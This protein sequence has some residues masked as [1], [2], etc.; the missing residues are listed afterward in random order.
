MATLQARV[1]ELAHW[2]IHNPPQDG[3]LKSW[4]VSYDQVTR[5]WNIK[6]LEIEVQWTEIPRDSK[7][8]VWEWKFLTQEWQPW[9]NLSLK[10]Q[11]IVSLELGH[12]ERYVGI[13]E[14]AKEGWADFKKEPHAK[15]ITIQ[16]KKKQE[17]S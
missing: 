5:Q 10:A 6:V 15:N 12:A 13:T 11:G 16:C 14:S 2:I 8:E 3:G 7:L 9:F 1:R 17:M 4:H